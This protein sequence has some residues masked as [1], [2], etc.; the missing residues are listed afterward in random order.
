M[1]QRYE[2][3]RN[4]VSENKETRRRIN[5][6]SRIL[7]EEFASLHELSGMI[8]SLDDD[9]VDSVRELEAVKE[10]EN[11]R[12][13]S[14]QE[15]ADSEREKITADINAEIDKL[16]AGASKLD[17]LRSFEFGQKS[18]DAAE[19]TYKSEISKFKE[20]LDE[21]DDDELQGFGSGGVESSGSGGFE[22]AGLGESHELVEGEEVSL[23]DVPPLPRV[24]YGSNNFNN[25]VSSLNSH[26]VSYRQIE[27]ARLNRSSEQIVTNISG[28]D[29]T[30]GSCSSLA[31]A[32]AGNRAGYNVL[33]FR[34]GE[35]R[36]F[37]SSRN[38]IRQIATLPGVRSAEL[39]GNNDIVSTH[40]LIDSI[41]SGK[42]YYLATGQHAAIVRNNN[43]QMQYLE[44]QHPSNGNGWHD[45]DDNVLIK[46]F[47]A[48]TN[49]TVPFSSFL[50][51]VDSLSNNQE[52]LNILGYINTAESEQRKGVSG[53][54]R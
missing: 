13:V 25:I 46:R 17:Q 2:K 26:G 20:L 6:E 7:S 50:I 15:Q 12:L 29:L 39:S 18:V 16:D 22:S 41:P 14:E 48:S 52:F 40:S 1:G 42:E 21:L 37:F 28:G 36:S 44:L 27:P 9:V 32:Y 38:S 24:T 35:S 23:I 33:D 51:E 49:H 45:L 47:G 53:N 34:D 10:A 43:G 3:N 31:L 8:D 30:D 19:K 4:N 54:V 11:N 5:E